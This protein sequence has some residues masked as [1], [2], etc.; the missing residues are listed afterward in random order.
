ML[1]RVGRRFALRLC[2][3]RDEI[4]QSNFVTLTGNGQK[5][6]ARHA[7]GLKFELGAGMFWRI[8]EYIHLEAAAIFSSLKY[9]SNE[10]QITSIVETITSYCRSDNLKIL[11][12]LLKR[13]EFAF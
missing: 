9:C 6:Q 11:V 13:S 8:S 12:L 2:E 1:S 5:R 7:R 4:W 3:V 10:E